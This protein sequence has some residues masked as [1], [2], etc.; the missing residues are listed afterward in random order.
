MKIA[1][2]TGRTA[3]NNILFGISTIILAEAVDLIMIA[4]EEEGD[5]ILVPIEQD[6]E[7]KVCAEFPELFA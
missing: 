4:D 6:A 3:D 7:C 1:P 2:A 5:G